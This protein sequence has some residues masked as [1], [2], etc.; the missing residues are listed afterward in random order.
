MDGVEIKSISITRLKQQGYRPFSERRLRD[1]GELKSKA[2]RLRDWNDPDKLVARVSRDALK[3]KASRLRDWN[4]KIIQRAKNILILSWNQKHLDYEIETETRLVSPHGLRFYQSWN[5]KHLDY[6]IELKTAP[7]LY[8]FYS[9]GWNQKHLDYEI[10]TNTK[11][12]GSGPKKKSWN[13]KHLDYEIETQAVH[14]LAT[15]FMRALKSKASRLRDWNI[16]LSP[17][18]QLSIHTV[19]IKSISITRLKQE[20]IRRIWWWSR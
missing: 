10:E 6:E 3:S 13:Q 12:A 4:V 8:W 17:M 20:A 16:S 9:A 5:Q 19:E 11:S 18:P 7:L 15:P 14:P 1:P 2:S